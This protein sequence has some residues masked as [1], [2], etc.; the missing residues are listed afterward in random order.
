MKKISYSRV[1]V[2]QIKSLPKVEVKKVI[3]KIEAI[4]SGETEGK[5]LKGE[6]DGLRSLRAWPY[7]I[8]YQEIG[9]KIEILSVKHRQGVYK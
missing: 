5:M 1:A 4:L 7:R 6:F 3:R 2:K 8:I 9:G